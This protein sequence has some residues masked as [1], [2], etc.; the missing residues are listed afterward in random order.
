MEALTAPDRMPV[1]P[2]QA[3]KKGFL[4]QFV[5]VSPMTFR[6]A[7]ASAGEYTDGFTGDFFA[8]VAGMAQTLSADFQ[9][10]ADQGI[11]KGRL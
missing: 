10:L 2:T 9:E 11:E 8:I 1:R 3:D 5:F 4:R 7:H 6:I